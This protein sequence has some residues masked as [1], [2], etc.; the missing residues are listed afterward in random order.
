MDDYEFVVVKWIGKMLNFSLNWEEFMLFGE[1][2]FYV[3]FYVKK[4]IIVW[5]MKWL[6]KVDFLGGWE[7]NIF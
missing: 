4:I 5:I 7:C 1:M 6:V 3:K 2:R